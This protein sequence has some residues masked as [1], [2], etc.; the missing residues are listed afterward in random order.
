MRGFPKLLCALA[1]AC[2]LS[3]F[4]HS[5]DAHAQNAPP[6]VPRGSESPS[7]NCSN[8]KTASAR[9][10][11]ADGELARLDGQIGAAFQKRKG[12]IPATEQQK[13]VAEQVAWIRERNSRCALV[14]KDS[15]P[16]EALAASKP[17]MISAIQER[18]ATFSTAARTPA[19]ERNAAGQED[20]AQPN[21]AL[22]EIW[23][24]PPQTA[25]AQVPGR[26]RESGTAVIISEDLRMPYG[27]GCASSRLGQLGRLT[28]QRDQD[29]VEFAS[30][31]MLDPSQRNNMMRWFCKNGLTVDIPVGT[32]E[33][34]K[35]GNIC[36][37]DFMLSKIVTKTVCSMRDLDY[38]N[39]QG[40]YEVILNGE[41]VDS[42]IVVS[43]TLEV[44]ILSYMRAKMERECP[45]GPQLFVVKG[46]SSTFGPPCF[47]VSYAQGREGKFIDWINTVSAPQLKN[48]QAARAEQQLQQLADELL[49][50][51]VNTWSL[52][53][54]GP[55]VAAT[56]HAEINVSKD[57][58]QIF[59]D[60][61]GT[62]KFLGGVA[63][64]NARR[65]EQVFQRYQLVNSDVSV[66]APCFQAYQDPS[67]GPAWTVT[68]NC[69]FA[70][71]ARIKFVADFAVA[72]WASRQQLITNPFLF[73][74][75]VMDVAGTFIRMLTENEAI[76]DVPDCLV[77]ACPDAIIVKKVPPTL[78]SGKGPAILALRVLGTRVPN[79]GSAIASIPDL[80]F[81]GAY[82][83][84]QQGCT[85][86]FDN[87][88]R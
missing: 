64:L 34:I 75:K 79:G 69:V 4:F 14:G 3:A 70:Q 11:C 1:A 76:F 21:T 35:R 42:D 19:Q 57:D 63:Q 56:A 62:E 46:C 55:V 77:A 40:A 80:E 24:K 48:R 72:G 68:K 61:S 9:L 23:R 27:A 73:K 22:P 37:I 59:G 65:C 12:E 50:V 26:A 18:I 15:S 29:N 7:F 74:D 83:C 53:C 43:P 36:T 66:N 6:L 85:D 81:V 52:S 31:C 71:A 49:G 17:C 8:A 20:T 28:S 86:F 10:I 16:I 51:K 13:F 44:A 39:F 32:T 78:F 41:T 87:G 5:S 47:L 38:P 2:A 45:A 54:M 33:P 82:R 67:K 84:T 58:M 88:V 60:K 30:I 25:Q